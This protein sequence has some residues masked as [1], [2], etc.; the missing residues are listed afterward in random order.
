MILWT[1]LKKNFLKLRKILENG[2]LRA[3]TNELEKHSEDGLIVAQ[4]VHV[5]QKAKV[6]NILHADQRINS[7]KV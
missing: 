2:F 4:E 1:I 7:A 3:R 5:H 6:E